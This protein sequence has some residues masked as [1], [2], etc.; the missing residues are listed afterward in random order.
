MFDDPRSDST[1]VFIR[2]SKLDE[3]DNYTKQIKSVSFHNECSVKSNKLL[4]KKNGTTPL[5]GATYQITKD[6][7]P[8][9]PSEASEERYTC[10]RGCKA[11]VP[12]YLKINRYEC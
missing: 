4:C 7:S 5:A 9:C 3:D 11:S 6:G 10:I 2:I 1:N 8:S 12:R